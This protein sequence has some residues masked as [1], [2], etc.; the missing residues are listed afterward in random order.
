M[1]IRE[2]LLEERTGATA[3]YGVATEHAVHLSEKHP[4]LC[5]DDVTEC[6]KRIGIA[7][8]KTD[9]L[10]HQQEEKSY[11]IKY[12]D[13]GRAQLSGETALLDRHDAA[14]ALGIRQ[15]GNLHLET[16]FATIA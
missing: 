7:M 9:L 15:S 6:Y 3:D 4:T 12:D 11:Q 10:P 13:L 2:E 1:R 5:E 16:W 14:E 8:L